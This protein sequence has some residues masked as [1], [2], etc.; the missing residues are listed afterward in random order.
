MV[1]GESGIRTHGP[2][3]RTT[4]FET[5]PFD[6]SGIS[7]EAQLPHGI[8]AANIIHFNYTIFDASRL[9]ERYGSEARLVWLEAEGEI[10]KISYSCRGIHGY[11]G[12]K[13]QLCV[14]LNSVSYD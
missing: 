1:C 14:F 5:A 4:V 10:S 3:T 12:L 2:V 9:Y 11:N 7:P 13:E 8:A 6:H